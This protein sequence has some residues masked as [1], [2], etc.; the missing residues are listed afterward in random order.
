MAVVIAILSILAFD[1]LTPPSG[2]VGSYIDVGRFFKAL[3]FLYGF[4]FSPAVIVTVT[5]AFYLNGRIRGR[6]Q[7]YAIEII[8]IIVAAIT[9][10]TFYSIFVHQNL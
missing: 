9:I 1:L 4:L 5:Y 10:L 2:T 8:S 7:S 3:F 6:P